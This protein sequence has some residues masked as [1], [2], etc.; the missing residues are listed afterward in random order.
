MVVP[1]ALLLVGKSDKFDAFSR[2][3]QHAFTVFE[4]H[5]SLFIL[6][7]EVFKRELFALHRVDNFLDLCEGIFEAGSVLV[8]REFFA[9]RHVESGKLGC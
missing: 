3:R 1:P 4:K 5:G 6:G 7:H 8:F 9:C 2:G